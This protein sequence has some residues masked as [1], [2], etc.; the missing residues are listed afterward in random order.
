MARRGVLQAR[1]VKVRDRAW[2]GAGWRQPSGSPRQSPPAVTVM[3]CCFSNGAALARPPDPPQ[4]VQ[5][6]RQRPGAVLQ[7][8]QVAVAVERPAVD[9]ARPAA[10]VAG[11]RGARTGVVGRRPAGAFAALVEPRSGRDADLPGPA[12][13]PAGHQVSPPLAWLPGSDQPTKQAGA[14]QPEPH[15]AH[16][17]YSPVVGPAEHQRCPTGWQDRRCR[18]SRRR[19]RRLS[20]HDRIQ[21]GPWPTGRGITAVVSAR[22]PYSTAR[23]EAELGLPGLQRRP[24]VGVILTEP[25]PPSS[26]LALMS[27]TRRPSNE[28]HGWCPRVPPGDPPGTVALG[29][30]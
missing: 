21:L 14:A 19:Y 6:R 9:A 29:V 27:P 30:C 28:P 5:L 25:D 4:P 26:R 10:G 16:P 8:L 23:R 13:L 24:S 22:Q 11:L 7:V 2:L 15:G 20:L 1:V 12:G 18:S 17:P 3:A